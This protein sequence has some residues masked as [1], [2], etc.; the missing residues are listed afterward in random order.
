MIKEADINNAKTLGEIEDLVA[1]C[2]R[3]VLYETKTKDVPGAGNQ[4]A[5]IMFIGEAPG[6]KED[7]EGMPF[8]G[9]A[10]KFLNEMLASI[11]LERED[12]YIANVV[13]HRPP[14]NRDP[15]PNEVEACWP[16][17][18]RQIEV[19]D[20]KL[21]VFLGRHSMNRFFPEF[22]IS[23]VHGKEFEKEFVGRNRTFLALYHPA[24]ALYNGGMR[25]TLKSDFANIPTIL[26]KIS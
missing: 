15:L 7:L 26:E 1:S 12:I 3:C 18:Q 5:E 4:S 11:G 6:K 14:N 2:D 22:K 24:A 8:I 23:E 16:Y 25:E 10:G 20:P 21:I 13:K 9:S 19:I 17:L